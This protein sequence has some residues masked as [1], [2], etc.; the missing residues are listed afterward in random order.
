VELEDY[1]KHPDFLW[2]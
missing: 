1:R 2:W